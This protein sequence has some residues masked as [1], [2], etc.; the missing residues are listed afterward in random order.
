MNQA[1]RLLDLGV[2]YILD[3]NF[4]YQ[5][6]SQIGPILSLHITMPEP[7]GLASGL[8]SMWGSITRGSWLLCVL[9]IQYKWKNEIIALCSGSF[10]EPETLDSDCWCLSTAKT[11]WLKPKAS[12]WPYLAIALG[13]S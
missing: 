2:F 9:Q 7:S 5:T 4:T 13:Q 3:H 6:K 10:V 12:I 1:L 8:L 11:R